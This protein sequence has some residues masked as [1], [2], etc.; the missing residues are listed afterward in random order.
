MG[1]FVPHSGQAFAPSG[2]SALQLL[3]GLYR[4]PHS[5]QNLVRSVI[6]AP[7]FEHLISDSFFSF[8]LAAEVSYPQRWQN[9]SFAD[10]LPLQL[11]HS[12]VSFVLS[13]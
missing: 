11:G 1:T 13:D 7:H 4:F 9:L 8:F 10:I 6:A 3:Q 12:F 2:M 5:G